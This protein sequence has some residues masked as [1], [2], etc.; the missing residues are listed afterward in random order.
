VKNEDSEEKIQEDVMK[1]MKF[2]DE[3]E[4]LMVEHEVS[5]KIIRVVKN[6]LVCF[7]PKR[8]GPNLLMNHLIDPEDSLFQ[9]LNKMLEGY[10]P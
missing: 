2:F 6:H 1:G 10:Q 7:G 3:F 9:W 5:N 8:C 4:G